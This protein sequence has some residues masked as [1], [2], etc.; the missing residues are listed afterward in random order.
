MLL[1]L[2][3]GLFAHIYHTYCNL[4]CT[5][6]ALWGIVLAYP[7]TSRRFIAYLYLF[8]SAAPARNHCMRADAQRSSFLRPWRGRPAVSMRHIISMYG[9][10]SRANQDANNS[11]LHARRVRAEDRG[12]GQAVTEWCIGNTL[13]ANHLKNMLS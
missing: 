2:S 6:A 13:Y 5:L 3:S 11:K 4:A 1:N 9:D 7:N 12:T 10:I 8:H